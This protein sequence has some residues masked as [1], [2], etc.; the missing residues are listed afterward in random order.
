[1]EGEG[2][3]KEEVGRGVRERGVWRLSDCIEALAS[4]GSIT[5]RSDNFTVAVS[6][7]GSTDGLFPAMS[8]DDI[9]K[10]ESSQRRVFS[11]VQ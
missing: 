1:M 6:K 8:T 2:E 9:L 11:F 4:K 3:Y 5:S 10:Y 7:D